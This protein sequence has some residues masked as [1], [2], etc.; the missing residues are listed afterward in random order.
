MHKIYFINK[1]ILLSFYN[2]SIVLTVFLCY[3]TSEEKGRKEK[4][5]TENSNGTLS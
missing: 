1:K 3:N 4:E 2:L 5:R